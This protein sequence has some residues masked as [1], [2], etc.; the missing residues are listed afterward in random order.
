MAHFADQGFIGAFFSTIIFAVVASVYVVRSKYFL[1]P[2][3]YLSFVS[4]DVRM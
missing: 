1:C 2:V 3:E 4:E